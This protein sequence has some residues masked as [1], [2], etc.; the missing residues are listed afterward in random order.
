MRTKVTIGLFLLPATAFVAVLLLV[1]FVGTLIQSFTYDNGLTTAS[2]AGFDNYLA[3]FQDPALRRSLLNTAFWTVGSLIFPV[4][5]GLLIAVLTNSLKAGLWIRLAIVLPYAISGVATGTVWKFMLNTDGAVNQL[6]SAVGLGG[7]A[8]SWLLTWPE[9]TFAM[10]VAYSWQISGVCVILYLVGLQSVPSETVE[11]GRLDGA[12][13]FRL[14]SQIVFP[15]LRSIT[16][17]VIGISLANGLRVFDMIWVLTGGGP[18]T[19]SETLA[20]SMYRAAFGLNQYGL[21]A[22]IAVVLTIIV[23]GSSWA[24]LRS[25]MPERQ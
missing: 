13:G 19:V 25:Q 17:V 9:N 22:A 23:L 15:Q 1:P 11:A 14:F 18:G 12:T 21:G 20:V 8:R 16:V 5:T 7:W 2:F 3:I 4:G 10:I 24:Y 6:L